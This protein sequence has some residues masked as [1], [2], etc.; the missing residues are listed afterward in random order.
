MQNVI[1]RAHTK[2]SEVIT[3]EHAY[4]G[5]VISLMDISPYKFDKPG[6]G[7][8]PDTTHVASVPDVYRGKYR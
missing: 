7:G 2:S 8:C 4:H 6:A 5:H 3:L 1:Y